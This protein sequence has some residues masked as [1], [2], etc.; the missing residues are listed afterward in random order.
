MKTYTG[1]D[2]LKNELE[3]LPKGSI[4]HKKINGKERV[5]LQWRDEDGKSRSKYLKADEEKEYAAM[6][7]RRRELE[8]Q[9]RRVSFN[10]PDADYTPVQEFKTS[11]KT[12]IQLTAACS[13]VSGFQKRDCY[14]SILKYL[15]EDF[16][17][18]IC[19]LFGLRRTG[20]TTL[21]FQA[22]NE[23]P[24]S[25]TAYIKI[26]TGDDMSMLSKDLDTLYRAG[27]RYVFIDEVTLMED[28]INTAALLSDIYT[29]MGMK[30][31]VSGTDSLG[32]AIAAS[33][34]LYDRTVTVHTSFVPFREYSRLLGID[35]VDAYIEYGGTL[36]MENMGFEDPDSSDDS[37][38]FRDDE[39]TRK[40]IDTS[41]SR[42]IQ[43]TLKN[44][45]FGRN[46]H[47]L[48]SLYDADELTNVI[49]RI[50]ESMNH[51][52]V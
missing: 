51:E 28:F 13:I 4:T 49:N 44:D 46:F 32:F 38:S 33:G 11:V 30:I 2:S 15:T 42:N 9:L 3:S 24:K 20:K 39:T 43:H 37:V 40:Y 35:S 52:F 18:R 48:R 19:V 36:R 23:L 1:Y 34:E 26:K 31:V 29:F 21:L 5:Y 50:I 27:F 25:E 22:I 8:S 14:S 45:S 17:G 6:V 10:S 16:P 7:E 12:G 47:Y 41:I